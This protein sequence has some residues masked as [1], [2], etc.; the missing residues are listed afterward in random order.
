MV[1]VVVIVEPYVV[2]CANTAPLVALT[3]RQPEASDLIF[4][5]VPTGVKTL[6]GS[7][8]LLTVPGA[9]SVKSA[10]YAI[11]HPRLPRYRVRH[12][13]PPD[14]STKF[15]VAG[16]IGIFVGGVVPVQVS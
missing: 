5:V 3:E 9:L 11:S 8:G 12:A 16:L 10:T 15:P 6:A 2:L 7:H 14:I 4:W 13:V 1:T